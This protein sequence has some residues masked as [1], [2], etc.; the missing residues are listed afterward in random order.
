MATDPDMNPPTLPVPWLL[1]NS[2][3]AFAASARSAGPGR[4]RTCS[5]A[6]YNRG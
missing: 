6:M 5:A 4:L 2:S 1:M 3:S